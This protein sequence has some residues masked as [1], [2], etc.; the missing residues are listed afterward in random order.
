[1]MHYGELL[2]TKLKEIGMS[3]SE[4][5][6]RMHMTTQGIQRM[7]KTRTINMARFEQ[8]AKVFDT[9][10]KELLDYGFELNKEKIDQVTDRDLVYETPLNRCMKEKEELQK[11]YISAM[12]KISELSMYLMSLPID[13]SK[14]VE[15]HRANG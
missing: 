11:K 1:M 8:A 13:R 3:K 14:L 10:A 5:A 9:T 12:E 2:E 15:L 4:F 6:R 7:L